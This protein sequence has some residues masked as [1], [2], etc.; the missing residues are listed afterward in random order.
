M[1]AVLANLYP[2]SEGAHPVFEV[3]EHN[4]KNKNKIKELATSFV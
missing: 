3:R 4:I 1:F 2:E